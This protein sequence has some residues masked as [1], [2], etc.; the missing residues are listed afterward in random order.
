MKITS[1]IIAACAVLSFARIVSGQNITAK[2]PNVVIVISD[3]HR[4]DW[5]GHKNS[6]MQ[7]PNLNR[8]AEQGWSFPNAFVNAGVCSP[9][10]AS[11]LTGKYMHQ[12]SAPDIVWDNNSFLRTQIMF[13]QRLKMLGYKTGYIGKFHLG[14]EEKPTPGFD[15]WASFEFVGGYFNQ[16][17]WVNGKEEKMSGFTDDNVAEMAKNTIE[18][19][20]KDDE[21]FCLIVGLKSPHIPFTYPERMKEYYEE[22]H[23]P[24][25]ETFYFDYSDSKPGMANNLINAR[26]WR[27]AI[28]AYGSFQEW[29]R[30]YTRL[31]TTIDQSVGTVMNAVEEAGLNGNTIFI[32]TSDH[33]YSL[34]EF[35]MCEKHY[36]YEQIIRIPMIARFPDQKRRG[37]PPGDMVMLMDIAPTVMDYCAGDI[38]DEMEGKSWRELEEPDGERKK[39]L[40]DALFFDFWHNQREILPPMQAIRTERYKLIDYEYM[41]YK[42]LY[43]LEKDPLEREN[44]ID[45]A[46]YET[47]KKDLEKRMSK[48]KKETDW[49]KRDKMAL[50][51]IYISE[52]PAS[53]KPEPADI[54]KRNSGWTPLKRENGVFDLSAYAQSKTCYI[55]IP[56]ENGS[57]YDPFIN[58]RITNQEN[59]KAAIPYLGYYKGEVIYSNV[60]WKTL[61]GIKTPA[62][63]GGFDFGYNAPLHAGQNVI[64]IELETDKGL[65]AELDFSV[66]GGVEKLKFL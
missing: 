50:N 45:S 12:A 48:W 15:L 42:E 18:E 6:L 49:V 4:H 3:D 46:G 13:P 17:I 32:Y 31:A 24:E 55:A 38:P 63:R 35:N 8:L 52:S 51:T 9:S 39:P 19:W 29:V 33:G 27:A 65:L 56:V 16:N 7:T 36:A 61:H 53:K 1:I 14:E 30:S 59:K 57:N 44:L 66:V 23:F 11:F 62:F 26:E 40:R 34:G 5:M 22:T 2:R 28:P 25:P 43:D 21:P 41:P 47:V 20:S 58:L 64:L 37:T 54:L 10:R 60:V